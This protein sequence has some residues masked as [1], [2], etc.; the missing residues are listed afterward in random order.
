MD[1]YL[2][3]E[4]DLIELPDNLEGSSNK[5]VLDEVDKYQ[6]MY[7]QPMLMGSIL[8][9][10]VMVMIWMHLMIKLPRSLRTPQC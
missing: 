1:K 9:K 4:L 3:E 10:S 2:V 8:R 6:L 5:Y 7:L